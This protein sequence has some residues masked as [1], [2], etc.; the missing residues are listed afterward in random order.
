MTF[1]SLLQLFGAAS[2][3]EPVDQYVAN[4]TYCFTFRVLEGQVEWGEVFVVEHLD[5]SR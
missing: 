2:L 5:A 3:L 1:G 4:H